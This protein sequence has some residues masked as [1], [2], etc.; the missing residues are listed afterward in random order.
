MS[1]DKASLKAKLAQRPAVTALH[2]LLL[3]RAE[4]KRGERVGLVERGSIGGD[5]RVGDDEGPSDG[6]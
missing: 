1:A 5:D 6:W 4:G 3:C 2:Q